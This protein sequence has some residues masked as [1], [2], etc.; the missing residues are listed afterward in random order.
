[1]QQSLATLKRWRFDKCLVAQGLGPLVHRAIDT[2]QVNVGKV[3]NQ[4]CL[5]CHVEAGPK[6]TEN[7]REEVATRVLQLFEACDSASVL[8]ITGG[9]PELN[10]NFRSMVSR[11]R[12]L[13]REV[14]DRCNLTV[15]FEPGM[16]D[17]PAFLAEHSVRIVASLPCYS[18]GNVDSQRG[19]G[20]FDKSIA[21]LRI[22]GG[23]GYGQPGSG[24]ELDLVYNPGGAFL[25]PAQATLEAQYRDELGAMG[26]A[27]SSLLTLSNLPVNRFADSLQREGELE[28]YMDLLS[29][30]F[31]P[32]T[33]DGL[34][35]TSQ[36]NVGWNGGIYDC[37]FNQMLE[38][39][40]TFAPDGTALN[41]MT[42]DS[43]S[44][45]R[46]APIKT[47]AHC[48]GCT[49]GAGSSCGGAIRLDT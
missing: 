48:F 5:H 47:A 11:A 28:G 17:L 35:C 21:A 39:P 24:L 43:F 6:R 8:D 41:V 13:G 1:M 3:C 45:L 34:M 36:V 16:Q 18:E 30:N 31:N 25:P 22:L 4:A 7:M 20:V 14:V 49:A 32:T 40:T 37:D 27:F 10:A 26:I 38:L 12:A 29:E 19:K 23:F 9:A 42:L 46:G 33:V 2:V 15:L 44:G